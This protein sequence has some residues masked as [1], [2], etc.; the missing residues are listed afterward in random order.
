M[1]LR[2]AGTIC[3]V[4]RGRIAWVCMLHQLSVVSRIGHGAAQVPRSRDATAAEQDCVGI[5]ALPLSW[6]AQALLASQNNS[7]TLCGFALLAA[8]THREIV[9]GT[10]CSSSCCSRRSHGQAH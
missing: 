2:R 6:A 4:L 10:L 8:H 9:A 7:P 3:S 5:L 1:A